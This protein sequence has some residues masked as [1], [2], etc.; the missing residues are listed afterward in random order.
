MKR[1]RRGQ[2]VAITFLDHVMGGNKPIR[3]VV[4]GKLVSVSHDSLTVAA[5]NYA[6]SGKDFVPPDDDVHDFRDGNPVRFTIVRS[7]ITR[8]Q[9]MVADP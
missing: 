3:F 8:I 7:A 2:I 4:Y 6:D 1:L 5:W 9:R